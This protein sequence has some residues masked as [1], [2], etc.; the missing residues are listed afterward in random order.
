MH[1]YTILFFTVVQFSNCFSQ[2]QDTLFRYYKGKVNKQFSIT[3][4]LKFE[5]QSLSGHYYYDKYRKAVN[6]V[7]ELRDSNLLVLWEMNDKGLSGGSFFSGTHTSDKKNIYGAWANNSSDESYV[8][9][10]SQVYVGEQ[11]EGS[12]SFE[13]VRQF[14]DFLNFFDLQISLPFSSESVRNFKTASWKN[15]DKKSAIN[16]YK[17]VIP[18]HLAK[19]YIMNKVVMGGEGSFNY[20]NIKGSQYNV[21]EMHY[22]ALCC[23]YR[24]PDYIG[25]L[26][27]FEDD[28]GWE[29]YNVTFLLMYDYAGNLKDGFKISKDLKL[30][31]GGKQ[32]RE[33]ALI[34]III[35]HRCQT[36]A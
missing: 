8:F 4:E 26:I 24:S 16:D 20:F 2:K 31:S 21:F 22:K 14:Q 36:R 6:I 13:D 1:F 32:I 9:E 19:K 27:S 25:L 18:Y 11:K 10:L 23:V 3:M 5:G 35:F 12:S 33:R 29:S 15:A 17:K 34:L 28:T 30:E 7:G